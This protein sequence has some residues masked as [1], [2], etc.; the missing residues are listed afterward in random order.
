M[1]IAVLALFCAALL[2]CVILD[3]TVLYALLFGLLIFVLYAARYKGFSFNEIL[4]LCLN[5]IKTV[6]NVL[7]I[8]MMIG[9]LTGLWRVSGTIATL[10]CYASD[11][12]SPSILLLM[13]FLL[14]CL[15]SLLTGS[16]FAS[17]AT[18]GVVCATIANAMGANII[19][20]GGAILS[21]VFFGDRC[22]PVS[23]SA[24]LVSELTKTSLYDNIKNMLRTALVPFILACAFYF[25]LG[26]TGSQ[27]S[28]PQE[29]VRE[30]FSSEFSLHFIAL[31]PAA[32]II[33][34]SL[35]RIGAKWIMLVSILASLPL[36]VFLQGN[37]VRET[38]LAMLTGFK[39]S[40]PQLAAMLNGGGIASMLKPAAIVLISA[41]YS[42]ILRKTGLLDGIRR[43][44][45][46]VAAH[47]TTYCATLLAS[48]LT[49]IIACN[50]SLCSILTHLLCDGL[51]ENGP[52][53][54]IDLEDTGVV[55]SPL[56]PWSIACALPL[57]SAGAPN[58]AVFF[59]FYLYLIPV[60]RILLSLLE[61]KGRDLS[62]ILPL[63]KETLS[64]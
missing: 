63:N 46:H 24:V 43:G 35:F 5:G 7:I 62:K 34:L 25:L 41:A 22:S 29:A 55:V 40:D 19:W 36:P 37:G 2:S 44:M 23:S 53:Q 27:A 11:L 17:C 1:E 3:L 45:E 58:S 20:I 38:L 52:R 33:I 10:V 28:A 47:T 18:M 4:S 57:T 48:A 61:K 54:A 31:L 8:F 64:S 60:W 12:I 16:S 39:A 9:V 26:Q 50:Q 49:G 6:K 32:L 15:V 56:I 42:E 59:A 51:Y 13:T 14:N 30:L 21:G